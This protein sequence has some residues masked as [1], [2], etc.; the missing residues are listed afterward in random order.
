[1]RAYHR[2]IRGGASVCLSVYL[3]AIVENEGGGRRKKKK[4]IPNRN[5]LDS[6]SLFGSTV[7][8]GGNH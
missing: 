4:R 6:I 1:M 7:A 5:V 8:A 3:S 2:H